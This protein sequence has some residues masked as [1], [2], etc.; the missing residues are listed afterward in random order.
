MTP[1]LH[2][3]V[4]RGLPGG[5]VGKLLVHREVPGWV[6]LH[7][8]DCLPREQEAHGGVCPV[9][10]VSGTPRHH[11]VRPEVPTPP[12][13]ARARLDTSFL[14]LSEICHSL[15]VG[16]GSG[17]QTQHRFILRLPVSQGDFWKERPKTPGKTSSTLRPGVGS[18]SLKHWGDDLIPKL[19]L[20]CRDP[21]Y[22]NTSALRTK[23]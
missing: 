22:L 14:Q 23:G 12:K 6:V 10:K 16:L 11:E 13:R 8:L 15:R 3:P 7:V 2:V 9:P 5:G 19:S 21:A 17:L 18:I 20:V 1:S 4:T